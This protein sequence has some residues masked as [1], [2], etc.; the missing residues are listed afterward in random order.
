M[1]VLFVVLQKQTKYS[2]FQEQFRGEA[3]CWYFQ[4]CE[5]CIWVWQ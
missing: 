4:V 5:L 2:S 1:Y 3:N